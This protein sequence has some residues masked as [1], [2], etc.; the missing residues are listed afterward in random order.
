M[1]VSFTPV[2]EMTPVPRVIIGFEAADVFAGTNRVT[3]WRIG[4]GQ[5]MKVRDGVDRSFVSSLSI[6]DLEA[7]PVIPVR[8]EVECWGVSGRLGRV[9]L[10]TTVLPWTLPSGFVILQQPLDPTLCVLVKNMAGS[11]PIVRR[12]APGEAVH[13]EGAELPSLVG[14][15]PRR[16]AEDVPVDFEASDR[17]TA[18]AV[19]ATLGTRAA[20]QL[21]VWLVRSPNPGLLPPVFFA[22]VKELREVDISVGVSKGQGGGG[23][24]RFRAV[25]QEIKPPAPALVVSLLSYDDLDAGYASYTARDAAYASYDEQDRD[26]SLAGLA[27]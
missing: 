5:E 7:P 15:G 27:G 18:A 11:W 16:G 8:Y 22:W 23:V 10:G 3:L 4:G 2:P 1:T 17:A 12:S 14:M 13:S 19:W 20:P 6:I 25:V 26:Y 21:Q 24:S 9:A